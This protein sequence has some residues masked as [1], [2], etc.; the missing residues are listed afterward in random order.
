MSAT[1]GLQVPVMLF[2]EVVGNGGTVPPA[3]MISV[4]PKLNVGGIFG[5]TATVNVAGNA[6][7]PAVG[8]KV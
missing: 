3:Q 8:V 1:V 2:D 7:R 5:L 6:Q 4:V